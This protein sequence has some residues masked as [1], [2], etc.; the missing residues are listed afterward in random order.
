MHICYNIYHSNWHTVPL[1]QSALSALAEW[2]QNNRLTINTKKTKIMAICRKDRAKF[3]WKTESLYISNNA[4][5][6]VNVYKYLEVDLDE[7]LTLNNMIDSTFNKTNCKVYLFKKIRP[8]ITWEIANHIYK[9]CILPI[10]D[11]ADFL[12][13]SG[14]VS[15]IGKLDTFK[16]RCFKIIDR[17][18]HPGASADELCQVYNHSS[19]VDRRK[20]HLLAVMYRH[21]L[22]NDNLEHQHP[23][24]QL[25]N[26]GKIKFKVPYTTLTKVQKNPFYRGVKLWERLPGGVQKATTKLKFK[27]MIK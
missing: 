18:L 11:Y 25:R 16:K 5:G 14:G 4:L 21:A 6:K 19:L 17:K 13:D 27:A 12:V 3:Y 2:C 8:Y 24:I 1:V 7:N 26:R 15:F 20:K 10:L 9:T 23:K 22:E